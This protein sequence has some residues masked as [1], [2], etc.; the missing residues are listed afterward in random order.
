MDEPASFQHLLPEIRAWATLPDDRRFTIIRTEKFIAYRRAQELLGK[1]DELVTFPPRTRPPSMLVFGEPDIGKSMLYNAFLRR[2]PACFEAD[3]GLRLSPAVG[4]EMPPGPSE[5]AFWRDLLA[6]IGVPMRPRDPADHLQD[7]ALRLLRQMR[8]RVLLVDEVHNLLSGSYREQ[9][10]MLNLLKYISNRVGVS[11]VGFGTEEAVLALQSD[12]QLASRFE[13]F[14]LERWKPDKELQGLVATLLA[15]MPLRLP[16]EVS[17]PE[18]VKVL[19][20][21]S[22]GI[23]GRLFRIIEI[24]AVQA[25][26]TGAERVDPALIQQ[27]GVTLL[28]TVERLT[29]GASYQRA[30]P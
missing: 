24:A 4:M 9:R 21:T 6:R 27:A 12:P 8:C 30:T 16:S 1:L 18:M 22:S 15:M 14:P 7:L 2:H 28:P 26:L 13:L 3:I 20:E 23:T 19:W 17:S 5:K 29:Q 25:I 11:L 10:R